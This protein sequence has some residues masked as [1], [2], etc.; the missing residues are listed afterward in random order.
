M[1]PEPSRDGPAQRT[2]LTHRNMVMNMGPLRGA[3]L[4]LQPRSDAEEALRLMRREGVTFDTDS[5]IRDG[6]FRT[7]DIG[8]RDEDGYYY[9][10]DRVK[11]LII[12]GGFN[13]YPREIEGVLITY[14]AVS[15]AAVVGVHHATHGEEAEAF[16]IPAAGADPRED[17]LIA[18]R[19]GGRGALRA[20]P[21]GCPTP[22][23][24][25]SWAGCT[26]SAVGDCRDCAETSGDRSPRMCDQTAM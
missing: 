10:V 14:P 12:R 4:V 8:R 17:E 9:V 13:V 21:E 23:G 7:G 24:G 19:R 15:V 1:R 22:P 16:V 18:W 25:T 3:T 11:D 26:N 6:W 20:G 2:E 5:A